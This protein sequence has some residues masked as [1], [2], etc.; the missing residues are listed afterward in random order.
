MPFIYF[1]YRTT[2]IQ[3]YKSPA[4]HRWLKVNWNLGPFACKTDASGSRYD[5]TY[6]FSMALALLTADDLSLK[7]IDPIN[8]WK[9]W[10]DL[11]LFSKYLRVLFLRPKDDRGWI[12]RLRPRNFAI[13][14]ESLTANL[15]KVRQ[16]S[17]W[18]TVPKFWFICLFYCSSKTY[19]CK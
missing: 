19:S 1:G 9:I 18:Q 12:L 16:T 8:I 13:I 10:N 11:R 3:H 6:L 5:L 7:F 17:V 4:K 14:S 2:C 15:E